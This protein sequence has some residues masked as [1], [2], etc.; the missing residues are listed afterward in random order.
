MAT[1]EHRIRRALRRLDKLQHSRPRPE[2]NDTEYLLSS[3]ENARILM[4]A[5]RELD[6]GRGRPTTM[7]EIRARLGLAE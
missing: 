3:P 1:R 4:E 5:I 7:A 2:R 6:E